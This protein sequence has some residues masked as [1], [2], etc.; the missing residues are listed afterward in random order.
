[1]GALDDEPEAEDE[2]EAGGDAAGGM[3]GSRSEA[4]RAVALLE[5]GLE[6]EEE[7]GEGEDGGD[8]QELEEEVGVVVVVPGRWGRMLA[9][10][11]AIVVVAVGG[12]SPRVFA[13]A[14]LALLPLLGDWSG[15]RTETPR[16]LLE[17]DIDECRA[18]VV[19]GKGIKDLKIDILFHHQ[20]QAFLASRKAHTSSR[21]TIVEISRSRRGVTCFELL[22]N[23][24]IIN[25]WYIT[26][27]TKHAR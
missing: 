25:N 8:T 14:G 1:E 7:D 4:V 6:E 23:R 16:F 5:A 17:A 18:G 15:P 3:A 20:R 9:W 11:L 2:D 10:V 27:D 22:R 26:E 19:P 13:A 24:L 21:L 12:V